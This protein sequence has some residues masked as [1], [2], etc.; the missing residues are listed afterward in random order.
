MGAAAIATVG[1]PLTGVSVEISVSFLDAAFVDV[2]ISRFF[3]N[4]MIFVSNNQ[5]GFSF[6]SCFLF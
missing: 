5:L 2:S 4:F 3:I 6:V 1:S